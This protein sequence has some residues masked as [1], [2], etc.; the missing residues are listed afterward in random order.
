MPARR[1]R[2]RAR[3]HSGKTATLNLS[4]IIRVAIAQAAPVCRNKAASL[5]KAVELIRKAAE[6]GA[7]L[8]AFGET[9]IRGYPVWLDICPDA[10]LWNHEPAKEAFS[11]VRNN[12]ICIDGPEVAQ[13]AQA[14]RDLH[15]SIVIGRKRS[16]DKIH[17]THI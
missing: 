12:S 1:S 4:S 3:L 9:W 11:E 10:A 7:G 13:L 8:I 16:A 5:A 15:I 2:A 6:L 17:T 14:A